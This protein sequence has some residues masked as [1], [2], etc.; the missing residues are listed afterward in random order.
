MKWNMPADLYILYIHLYM[1]LLPYT[2]GCYLY[3]K[4]HIKM[5]TLYIVHAKKLPTGD[6][7][8]LQGWDSL[9]T[10]FPRENPLFSVRGLV[11]PIR[12]NSG[13]YGSE[14]HVAFRLISESFVLMYSNARQK[15]PS[16]SAAR[17]GGSKMVVYSSS[18]FIS[19]IK[20]FN[21]GLGVLNLYPN[22]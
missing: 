4:G 13:G 10:I 20:R 17:G 9:K 14:S 5:G 7:S 18:N 11:W 1:Y 21:S 8:L 12:T 16:G 19:K 15:M 22:Y 6:N 2:S 3:K